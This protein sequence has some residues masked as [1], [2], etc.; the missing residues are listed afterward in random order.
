MVKGKWVV[1]I[2]ACKSLMIYKSY[3]NKFR[4]LSQ[5]YIFL[6]TTHVPAGMLKFLR[7]IIRIF[8]IRMN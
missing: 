3:H 6:I 5:K 7:Y 1:G 2:T 8:H 4:C